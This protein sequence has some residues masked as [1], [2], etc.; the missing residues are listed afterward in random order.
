[1]TLRLCL[2]EID[3]LKLTYKKIQKNLLDIDLSE[4]D[5][6]DIKQTISDFNSKLV[7]HQ[8]HRLKLEFIGCKTEMMAIED[9]LLN[10]MA[11]RLQRTFRNEFKRDD[12]FNIET[13][14]QYQKYL[15]NLTEKLNT[16]HTKIILHS[17][18]LDTLKNTLL[19]RQIEYSERL[20]NQK[21]SFIESKKANNVKYCKKLIR[22]ETRL[23]EFKTDLKLEDKMIIVARISSLKD[24]PNQKELLDCFIN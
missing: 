3:K 8:K 11:I 16:I 23:Y 7:Y 18:E 21:I 14:N 13:I 1:M 17:E 15:L 9:E 12:L 19:T 20:L 24:Y 4:I 5:I 6:N 10:Q 22:N 2:S